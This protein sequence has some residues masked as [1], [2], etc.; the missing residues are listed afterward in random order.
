MRTEKRVGGA[1]TSQKELSMSF[2]STPVFCS[3]GYLTDE[4]HGWIR[5]KVDE[6]KLD[7]SMVTDL[8]FSKIQMREELT[9]ALQRDIA[10]RFMKNTHEQWERVCDIAMLVMQLHQQRA[11][12]A[13][14][15]V[16]IKAFL[17]EPI[18][19]PKQAT[20]KEEPTAK[21]ASNRKKGDGVARALTILMDHPEWDN[22]TIAAKAGIDKAVLSRSKRFKTAR[23]MAKG[24]GMADVSDG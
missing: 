10:L 21:P 1:A 12:S 3:R 9:D 20:G 13:E 11:S 8:M 23:K 16:R 4:L 15:E 2:D 14:R 24:I 5:R 22:K 18:T 7:R 17:A 19:R 6:L